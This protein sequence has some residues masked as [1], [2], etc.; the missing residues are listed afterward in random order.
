MNNRSSAGTSNEHIIYQY[1][2]NRL[3][4][5]GVLSA[6]FIL[7]VF[8][9]ISAI[10]PLAKAQEEV[11]IF[12]S[13]SDTILVYSKV[14]KIR[15]TVDSVSVAFHDG[16]TRDYG[17]SDI[18]S[19][20][21]GNI[22]IQKTKV[23]I[24]QHSSEA[25]IQT[26]ITGRVSL[27]RSYNSGDEYF[28][29]EKDSTGIYFVPLQHYLNYIYLFFGDCK[30]LG[31]DMKG[32]LPER[33]HYD[34]N[35]WLQLVSFYNEKMGNSL[36]KVVYYKKQPFSY[37]T[38]AIAGISFNTVHMNSYPY[39]QQKLGYGFSPALGMMAGVL[40]HQ[41][42]GFYS[43]LVYQNLNSTSDFSAIGYRF[44]DNLNVIAVNV[45][46]NLHY[47]LNVFQTPLV[48]RII[49]FQRGNVSLYF[50]GGSVI[51]TLISNRSHVDA[52]DDYKAGINYTYDIQ[53]ESFAIGWYAGTGLTLPAFSKQLHIAF[54]VNRE[55]WPLDPITS[56]QFSDPKSRTTFT[57]YNVTAGIDF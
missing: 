2:L 40:F 50:E 51:N 20:R 53:A 11:K 29:L 15:F 30:D 36:E 19:L 42:I 34:L 31:L 41:K 48:I 28:Y 56:Y 13:G 25:F 3:K 57:G 35:G 21:S 12:P 24:D 10:N 37:E 43:G 49:P 27:Y 5:S 1:I 4:K 7:S 18:D 33:F 17:L 38:F 6:N 9:L 55:S 14:T 54:S 45:K 46:V 16:I 23:M 47:S 22:R 52:D 8:V 32:S 26:L 44:D 39:N